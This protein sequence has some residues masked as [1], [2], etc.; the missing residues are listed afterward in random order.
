MT[1]LFYPI[2]RDKF[3][4]NRNFS[5]HNHLKVAVNVTQMHMRGYQELGCKIHGT[6]FYLV[7]TW[8]K[9]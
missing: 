6:Y 4:I 5:I 1:N 8:Y 9:L 2:R 7:L 3:N